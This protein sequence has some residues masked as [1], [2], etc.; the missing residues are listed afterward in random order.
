[1]STVF[2]V[3]G[4]PDAEN[5]QGASIDILSG[6]NGSKPRGDCSARQK[7]LVSG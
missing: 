3:K 5:E 2:L 7:N 4:F 1:M 6:G